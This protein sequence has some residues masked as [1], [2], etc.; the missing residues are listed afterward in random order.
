MIVRKVQS[1]R[2]LRKFID[3]GYDHYRGDPH[4]VPPLRL[5]VKHTLN[6]RKNAFF[7]HGRIQ[8]FLAEDENGRT[9]GRIAA[10]I[11]GM[12]LEKYDDSVGF[13]GFFETVD[14]FDVAVKLMGAAEKWLIEYGMSG[15]RGPVNPSMN[16]VAGLLV[17]GF[18]KPPFVMMPY[19]KEYY[20]DFLARLGYERAMTMWAWFIHRKHGRFEKLWRGRDLI[21]RRYPDLRV[22]TIDMSRFDEEA[23]AIRDIY[24]E[25]WSDNWGHVP[26]TEAEFRQIAKS[27]K[28]IIEPELVILVEDRGQPIAFAITLPN[29]NQAL[30]HVKDGR[31]LPTGLFQLFMRLKFGGVTE[32]RTLLM[33]VRKGY[34]GRGLDSVLVADTVRNSYT[35]GF[36]AGELSWVLESNDVLINQLEAIGAVRDK[37]YVMLEKSLDHVGSAR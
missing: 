37:E 9:L 35:L 12:H 8:C 31:L 33:G 17:E 22:R 14:D 18:D 29:V 21:V 6:P 36:S 11:N 15:V 25:A 10:I 24:N 28:Q 5:D 3:F 19:N 30:K 13:F 20:P 34:R 23:A 4:W 16:D 26:M 7:E 27:M 1:A 32:A 2:D